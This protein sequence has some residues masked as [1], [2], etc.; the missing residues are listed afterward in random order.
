MN[1]PKLFVHLLFV[2]LPVL[3]SV[4][5]GAQTKIIH[6]LVRDSHSEEPVPFVS[7]VFKNSTTGK[8]TDSAGHFSFYLAHLPSDTLLLADSRDPVLL[9]ETGLPTR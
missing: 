1:R 9:F 7:V 3:A 4:Q 8:L 6:G 5:A 2:M